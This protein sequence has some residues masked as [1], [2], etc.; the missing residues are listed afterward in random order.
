MKG[1]VIFLTAL[2]VLSFSCGETSSEQ[3]ENDVDFVS[4]DKD[5]SLD[6]LDCETD[7]DPVCECGEIEGDADGDGIPN[8]VEGCADYDNDD[9]PACMDPDS[10]GDDF[11]DEEECPKLPCRDTD[12]DQMPDFLD[13]D[14]DND[15]LGDG[16]EK[17]KGTDPLKTDTDGDGT[18]DWTEVKIGTDP[19][20]PGE[21]TE[22]A[23]YFYLH[24]DLERKVNFSMISESQNTLDH[25]TL[26]VI[27]DCKEDSDYLRNFVNDFYP[28]SAKPESGVS[29]MDEKTFYDVEKNTEITFEAL[30]KYSYCW[31]YNRLEGER[32]VAE[33]FVLFVSGAKVLKTEKLIIHV[34]PPK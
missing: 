20:N 9:L 18:D 32:D 27:G 16:Y 15:L 6:D 7:D 10:D 4:D 12:G 22:D 2:L 26:R 30:I 25:I 3:I 34:V 5:F 23:F 28:V 8:I 31:D 14:S 21:P 29:S 17:Y 13:G 24:E 19:L 11:P 33:L 1:F